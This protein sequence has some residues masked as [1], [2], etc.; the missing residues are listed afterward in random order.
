MAPMFP[1]DPIQDDDVHYI[2]FKKKKK[3]KMSYSKFIGQLN[4]LLTY[5]PTSILIAEK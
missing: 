3:K 2:L 5:E 4:R 1:S